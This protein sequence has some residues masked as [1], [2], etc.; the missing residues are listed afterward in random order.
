MKKKRKSNLSSITSPQVFKT[1]RGKKKRSKKLRKGFTC[2]R[3]NNSSFKPN[4]KDR[5]LVNRLSNIKKRKNNWK[6]KR[7]RKNKK[8]SNPKLKGLFSRKRRKSLRINRLRKVRKSRK[9]TGKKLCKCKLNLTD[10]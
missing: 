3:N 1:S 9:K 2:K 8:L 7:Q 10:C 6:V 5:F 4:S